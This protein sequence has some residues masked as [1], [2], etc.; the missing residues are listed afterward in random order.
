MIS[1]VGMSRL[2]SGFRYE[3]QLRMVHS[4]EDYD[5]VLHC[6]REFQMNQKNVFNFQI[7]WDQLKQHGFINGYSN[8]L[9]I[10]LSVCPIQLDLK[11]I[12]DCIMPMP[13]DDGEYSSSTD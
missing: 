4:V 8:C 6:E 1:L 11:F 3:V 12:Q 9:K 5:K 10:R 13:I 7:R 2:K